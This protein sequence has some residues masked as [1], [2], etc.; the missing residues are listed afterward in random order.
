MWATWASPR[1]ITSWSL[2]WANSLEI[3]G[4]P[5]SV[6]GPPP[7][8]RVP[9]YEWNEMDFSGRI[10][11]VRSYAY[12]GNEKHADSW[13]ERPYVQQPLRTG[14]WLFLGRLLPPGRLA[15]TDS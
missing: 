10:G 12:R 3:F 9:K 2:P 8:N 7:G 6:S 13:R 15:F 4:S 11:P 5:T 14:K 1:L